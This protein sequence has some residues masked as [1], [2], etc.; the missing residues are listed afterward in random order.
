MVVVE[1]L[2]SEFEIEFVAERGDAFA[3]VLRLD[4]EIFVVV[5]SEFHNGRKV[6]VFSREMKPAPRTAF[7]PML[8]LFFVDYIR[9]IG[10]ICRKQVHKMLQNMSGITMEFLIQPEYL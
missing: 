5:E 3:D 10:Y 2:S 9:E 4:A 8:L 7:I 1:E 6:T